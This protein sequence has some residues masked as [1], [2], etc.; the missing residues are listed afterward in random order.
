MTGGLR[1][2]TGA[3]E[4]ASTA[5]PG[6]PAFG[7]CLD[8]GR[9]YDYREGRCRD[10][11]IDLLCVPCAARRPALLAGTGALAVFAVVLI[12]SGWRGR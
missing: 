6:S 4:K 10:D 12:V 8:S 2:R 9:L 3:I 7:R 11:V 5:Q 1:D